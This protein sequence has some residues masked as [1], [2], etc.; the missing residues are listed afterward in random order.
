[1]IQVVKPGTLDLVVDLGRPGYRALGVPEGGAADAPALIRANRLV[2]NPDDAAGLEMTLRGPELCFPDGAAVALTGADMAAILDGVYL[3]P[4]LRYKVR[5]GALLKFGLANA[6]I[7]AYLAVAGGIDVPKVLASRSTFL[8]G[9]W[10]GW[11]GRALKA[12]DRL[13]VG[14]PCGSQVWE[15]L[16]G[17]MPGTEA[18]L[19]VLPGPQ[20]KGFTDA[21]LARFLH[22]A[23]VVQA[24]ANRVGIR[25]TGEV[26]DYAK[27]E[28]ASQ[29]VL[30][31]AIQVP[32]SG[33]PIILGWD[34][35]VTG[36]YPVIAGVI[37]ADLPRL[38]QFGPGDSLRF[39]VV[40]QEEA[41]QA[42]QRESVWI[43]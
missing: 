17:S 25:L 37:A 33:Q 4:C 19:R 22:Q 35:P 38:A 32:P 5:P 8:P 34:G 7:R 12:G 9:G 1:M 31:G 42:W 24:D 41:L 13:P 43:S 21:S 30:P 14:S 10:G 29:A 27:G 20:L 3:Q 28:I 16:P 2:G 40:S 39:R 36:G 23:F 11:Q 15:C 26:L 6:G 18:V